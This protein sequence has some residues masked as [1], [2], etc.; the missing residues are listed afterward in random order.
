MALKLDPINDVTKSFSKERVEFAEKYIFAEHPLLQIS[1]RI[2]REAWNK[3]SRK[4]KFFVILKRKIRRVLS[5]GRSAKKVQTCN[6]LYFLKDSNKG[7]GINLE[8]K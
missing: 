1:R 5:C 2:E 6:K 7:C 8:I 3:L 4:Q